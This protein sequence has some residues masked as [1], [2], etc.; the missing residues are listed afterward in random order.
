[1]E[2][3]RK[4]CNGNFDAVFKS[5]YVFDGVGKKIAYKDSLGIPFNHA[6]HLIEGLVNVDRLRSDNLLTK[7]MVIDAYKSEVCHKS[8][9]LRALGPTQ[10]NFRRNVL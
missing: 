5:P 2:G 1:M 10:F 4:A 6:A 8:F 9:S 3:F 7:Q